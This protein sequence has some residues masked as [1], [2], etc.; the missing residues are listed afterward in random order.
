M[1]KEI[2]KLS[3]SSNKSVKDIN[4]FLNEVQKSITEIAKGIRSSS[5]I[6]QEQASVLQNI[7]ANALEIQNHTQKSHEIEQNN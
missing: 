5:K 2:Q 6:S 1:A 4:Q 7:S 3:Y